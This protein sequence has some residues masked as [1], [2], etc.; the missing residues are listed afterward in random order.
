MEKW[1]IILLIVSIG[2]AFYGIVFCIKK[3]SNKRQRRQN[4]VIF[5][6]ANVVPSTSHAPAYNVGAPPPMYQYQTVTA[7]QMYPNQ[8]YQPPVHQGYH[9]QPAYLHTQ[10]QQ[11]FY[12]TAPVITPSDRY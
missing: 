2:L 7:Q 4:P 9:E 10:G 5:T 1:L 6:N 12:P 8:Q 3:R 11:Q